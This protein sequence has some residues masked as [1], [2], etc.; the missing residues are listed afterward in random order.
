MMEKA[1]HHRRRHVWRVLLV[2]V[3]GCVFLY[4]SAVS[5]VFSQFDGNAKLPA[6][7]AIVFGTAVRPRRNERG[8]IASAEAGPGIHRRV[9]AAAS[10][11]RSGMVRRVFVTGGRGEGMPDSEAAVM[12][13]LAVAQ[14][15]A[16]EDVVVE[17][18]ASS[19]KENLA[20][21]QPL[22]KNCDSVVAVSDR[23]HLARI[24]LLAWRMGW[25]LTTYPS[26]EY[27]GAFFEAR[28]VMR[29]AAGLFAAVLGW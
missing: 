18:R 26:L 24:Q 10:L 4:G 21:T 25:T 23:Y 7:C 17:D 6:D 29:E 28:S 2:V 9:S 19:T 1:P 11:Y 3:F 5:F 16:E 14:G 27:S 8:E 22:A 20:L 13:R 15:I 12:A